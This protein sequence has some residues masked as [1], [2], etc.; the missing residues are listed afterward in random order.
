MEQ[1]ESGFLS[2]SSAHL[3]PSSLLSP[4]TLTFLLLAKGQGPRAP[5]P[6]GSCLGEAPVRKAKALYFPLPCSCP[7]P[8][9]V[10]LLTSPYSHSCPI[11]QSTCLCSL[12]FQPCD[13]ATL[14]KFFLLILSSRPTEGMDDLLR[15]RLKAKDRVEILNSNLRVRAR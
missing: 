6:A 13:F 7:Y 3:F 12:L 1:L 4:E 15:V 5:N 11:P 10:T 2:T 8:S 9:V 14:A